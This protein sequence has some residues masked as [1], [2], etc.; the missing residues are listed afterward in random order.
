MEYRILHYDCRNAKDV[1][2]ME[3]G[4][5]IIPFKL[6]LS[7]SGSDSRTIFCMESSPGLLVSLPSVRA[8]NRLPWLGPDIARDA[9]WYPEVLLT[10]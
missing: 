10:S 1:D 7:V 2:V 8:Y 5:R 4:F 6:M 3:V 9:K